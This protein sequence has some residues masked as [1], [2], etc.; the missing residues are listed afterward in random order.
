MI[1]LALIVFVSAVV[2]RY[3]GG[4]IV[5]V[6]VFD[7]PGHRRFWCAPVMA[8]LGWLV[9]PPV[10]DAIFGACWLWWSILP[11]GRWYSL[12]HWP[13]EASGAP[14]AFERVIE[15]I[16][17]VNGRSDHACLFLRNLVALA[18]LAT[19]SPWAALIVLLGQSTAY[20]VSW[21]IVPERNG[22]TGYAEYA[23]GAG[24]GAALLAMR[25]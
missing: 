21:E 16:G 22:P 9:L 10:S 5:S 13:R 11:W 23:T 17:D 6:N 8:A 20:A 12:G 18:P 3:R 1:M 7:P 25:T 15:R 2:N 19:L 4:G 14:D 24:W